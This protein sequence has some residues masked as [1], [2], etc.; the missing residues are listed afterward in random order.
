MNW[1]EFMNGMEIKIFEYRKRKEE[2]EE[3]EWNGY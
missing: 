3:E 1:N 2:K